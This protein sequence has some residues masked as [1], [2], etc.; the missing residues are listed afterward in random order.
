VDKR[1]GVLVRGPMSRGQDDG[2]K[3]HETTLRTRMEKVIGAME[4]GG[5]TIKPYS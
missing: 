3:A 5:A 2:N 4:G 1:G